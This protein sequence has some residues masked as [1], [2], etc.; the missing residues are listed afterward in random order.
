MGLANEHGN[1]LEEPES[2]HMLIKGPGAPPPKKER[3]G[4][5]ALRRQHCKV[6]PRDV[7]TDTMLAVG[8]WTQDDPSCPVEQFCP[9]YNEW[10]VAA[11]MVN[12]R[13]NAAVGTLGGKVYTAGGQDSIRCYDNVERYDPHTD[14]WSVEIAPLSSPR[15][16]VCLLETDGYLYAIGGWDGIT[17]SSAVERYDPVLNSWSRQAPMRTRR[18]HSGAV[19]LGGHLYVMGGRDGDTVL[20]SVERYC[21]EE[22]SWSACPP[23]RSAREGAGCTAYLGQLYVAGGRDEL[24]LDLSAVERYDPDTRRWSPVKHMTCKRNQASL[25]VFNGALLAAGGSDGVVHLKSVEVYN[26]ESNTWR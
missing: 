20:N 6:A 11:P 2:R 23:M 3:P 21:P 14:V 8:G 16:G 7:F 10:R 25:V 9:E 4:P 26:P 17:A 22:G 18:S 12:R 19:L 1:S 13:G 15:T 24:R 5:L